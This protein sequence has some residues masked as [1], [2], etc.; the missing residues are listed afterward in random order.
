MM[1]TCGGWWKRQLQFRVSLVSRILNTS[2]VR[3]RGGRLDIVIAPSSAT[4]SCLV[5][6]AVPSPHLEKGAEGNV[7]AIV[8]IPE[9][10]V[11]ETFE[12]RIDVKYVTAKSAFE[13]DLVAGATGPANAPAEYCKRDRFWETDDPLIKRTAER[14]RRSSRNTSEFLT[15]TFAW[16]RDNLKLREPQPTRLGAARAIRDLTGDCDEFSDLFIALC[17]AANVASRRVVGLFYHE[18]EGERRSFDWHAWAEVQMTPSVWI[19]FDPSLN[20]LAGTSERHLPR[21]CMGRRSDY[22]IRRLTWRS[23]PN[24]PPAL[25]DDDIESI[26][27]ASN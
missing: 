6:D 4:D 21:C 10:E 27:V 7:H 25:N 11:E 19:P 5:R 8:K 15:Q 22:P 23:H 24:R 20:F 26:A 12:S 14:I 3:L 9:L 18:R 13:L 1:S 17:R 16:I 2:G